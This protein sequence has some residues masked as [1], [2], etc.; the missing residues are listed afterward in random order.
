MTSTTAVTPHRSRRD[1]VRPLPRSTGLRP[2][3][4][5]LALLWLALPP[6]AQAQF[7]T[8]GSGAYR[9]NI[10]WF[11]WGNG[12]C[13]NSQDNC[14]EIGNN[15]ANQTITSQQT[16]NVAGQPLVVT[17]T[18]SGVGNDEFRTYRSGLWQGDG[19]DDL[20]NIGGVGTANTLYNGLLNF[21]QTQVST[22]TFACGATLGGNPFP[23]EGLVVADAEQS[24]TGGTGQNESISANA[25]TATSWRIIDRFRTPGCTTN[26]NANI[27]GTTLTLNGSTPLCTAGPMA[28]AFMEGATSATLTLHGNGRSAMALGVLVFVADRSDAPLSYGEPQHLP[29]FTWNGGNLPNGNTTYTTMTLATLNQPAV[30]LGTRVDIENVSLAGAPATGDDSNF[31]TPTATDDEDAFGTLA[32]IALS[33]GASHNLSVPCA[34]NGAFVRGFIDFNRDGDFTDAGETSASATCNG[35]AAAVTWTMPAVAGLNPGASYARFRIA[36]AA[37]DVANPVGLASSGEVEDYPVTLTSQTLTLRKQWTGAAVGDDAV[38]TASRGGS[39]IDT[40]NSN[41]DAAGELETDPTPA[42]VFAGETIVLAETLAAGNVGGYAPALACTG[43]A[44]TNPDD[45][46]AIAATDTNIVCT[47]TNTRV[48]T[49]QLAKAWAANSRTGDTLT[50]GATTGGNNN[51]APFD[52]TAPTAANSGAPVS[53]RLGDVVTLPAETGTGL[54][55]YTTTLACTGGHTLSGTNGQVANTLTITSGNAAVCTYTNT[56][57]AQQINLAKVWSANSTNGHTASA[58]TTGGTAN[59]TFTATAPTNNAGPAVTVFAGDVL[60][61]PAE[62]FGGGATAASY[63]TALACTGGSPLASGATGRTLT[64][65]ASAAATTCTYTNTPVVVDLTITKTNTFAAGPRDQANDTVASGATTTY[66]LVAT[67]NGPG[68]VTGSMVR[69]TPVA[70][71]TCPPANAVTITGNGVPAGSFTVADLSAG[72]ALGTLGAGQSTTLSFDCQVN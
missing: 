52:A 9:N 13:L 36:S 58:T 63:T 32:N 65:T 31:T 38:I 44:D 6:P 56:R 71:L 33:P 5:T 34:G 42:N 59:P 35:T 61:L 39:V 53:V 19:L 28:V 55:N 30:R 72:I 50:I 69:D 24:L 54:G 18:L 17:C 47:Y 7:A 27:T 8:Q 16:Y 51:T 45:G 46:I 21:G 4:L 37:I 41:A 10:I 1:S 14:A 29:N 15:T 70:G 26:A 64:I 43:A 60:T 48:A 68:E 62:T 22:A 20:Y 12:T 40:L 49:L 23:L 57:I 2:W 66:T 67:N 25:P 3:A 11:R